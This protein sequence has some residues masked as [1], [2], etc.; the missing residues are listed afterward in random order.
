[1]KP[2][3]T[4]TPM[5]FRLHPLSGALLLY[6]LGCSGVQAVTISNVPLYLGTST[7]PNVLFVLANSQNM[8]ENG[9]P[10]YGMIGAAV[11]GSSPHSKSEIARAAIRSL[12]TTYFGQIN[13]GLMTFGQYTPSKYYM[14]N[15]YYDSRYDP[16]YYNPS[17]VCPS[18]WTA[19]QC[20]ASDYK[21]Y[22]TVNPTDTSNYIY[23]NYASPFYD[24]GPPFSAN[25]CYSSTAK[26]DNTTNVPA[27]SDYY[28]CYST[29]TG[30]S[31]ASPGTSGSGYSGYLGGGGFGP[32]DSDYANNVLDFGARLP[33]VYTSSAWF[34]N[35]SPGGGYLRTP[36][37]ALTSTQQTTINNKLV[38]NMPSQWN[39][40]NPNPTPAWPSTGCNSSTLLSSSIY[41]SGLTAIEG[42]LN[43]AAS[44]F[45]GT[46]STSKGAT[47]GY[48][49]PNSCG[50]NFVVLLTNGLPSVDASGTIEKTGGQ[51]DTC[52]MTSKAITAATNL[53]NNGNGPKLYVVGYALPPFAL[54][55]YN[56]SCGVTGNPL[57]NMAASGGTGT[58][59]TASDPTTLQSSLNTVFTSILQ[60]SGS[61]AAL[62]SNSTSINANSYVYQ[63]SFNTADWSGHLQAI[64]VT[65][66]GAGTPAWDAATRIPTW[67][68]R[69]LL[70]Y[71]GSVGKTFQWNNLTT[72]EQCLLASQASGCTLTSA[73]TTTGQQALNYISGD[74]SQAQSSG[75]ALRN[76]SVLLG[77]IVDSN[78]LYL[79]QDDYGYSILSGT[80]GSSY[81]AYVN[82]KTTPMLYAG[83]NDGMLHAFNSS[84]VEQFA[85]IPSAVYANLPA[86]TQPSY[87]SNHQVYVDGSPGSGD[88]YYA[89]AWHTILIGTLGGGGN[90]IFALD[91]TNPTTM[92]ASN[93]MWEYTGASNMGKTWGQP[94][95]ARFNDGHYYAVVNNGYN[96][97]NGHAVLYLIQVDSPSNVIK[98]DAGSGGSSCTGGDGLSQATL[99]D[100][101]Q[102]GTI[103]AIYAGDL[104]GNIWK[105][106]VSNTMA[107][108]W[109]VAF[110]SGN[111]PLPLFTAKDSIGNLQPIT[112]PLVLG[113][114]PSGT[115]GTAMVFF[116]T[117]QYLGPTDTT[118]TNTQSLYGVL[119]SSTFSSGSFSGG[120]NSMVRSNLQQ[121]SIIFENSV[122]RAVSS[123]S[124]TY[125]TSGTNYG[126]YMD[127]LEPTGTAQIGER[128]ISQPVLRSG[129]IL[130]TTLIPNTGTC[131]YGGTGWAME[132]DAVT[133]GA[134]S[135]T[136][137]DINNDGL[138]D[139]NDNLT[140]S[141]ETTAVAVGMKMTNGFGH[142]PV[143]LT[144]N[145]SL[146]TLTN[147]T[148]GNIQSWNAKSN[149]LSPRASWSQIQ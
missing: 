44:Y 35:G 10:A 120:Q 52:S 122:S 94:W 88:A 41:N 101:D 81:P 70:T 137:L 16:S 85:Y 26:F 139:T 116:G 143:T 83:A 96:S 100:A 74:T 15:S 147:T 55:Y 145:G 110:K 59:F 133:G 113:S 98:I 63:A 130:F 132:L 76:R 54:Q 11:G 39:S 27:G 7:P 36:L 109:A 2:R 105:F 140:L 97:T 108:K 117:G 136:F 146:V 80:E 45:K 19:I 78:P 90:S 149:T 125:P 135:Y 14:Y 111:T 1:M 48:T 28:T 4:D 47:S 31:D 91:V 127:L 102:N 66:S 21:L 30:T 106:D 148:S 92:T 62:T 65:S 107:S 53:Y 123:H 121:Q 33:S 42:T 50:K 20:R 64:P 17:Y 60:S 119:D 6:I 12:E 32:T 131:S 57:D 134:P 56:S 71:N 124:V 114:T 112:A 40:S 8:D 118:N 115:T 129:R 23:Y 141:D 49:L 37:A 72:N 34:Y 46:L 61:S 104:C 144:N 95:V 69:N 3:R 79:S 5:R 75:G 58:S 68:T 22:R 93:V 18:G 82:A 24:N 87:N 99:L 73:Q 67:N 9:D 13:L 86:L 126:W 51:I 84:G 29:K 38:C 89:G 142:T 77:D 128:V 25:F 43:D 103:D 138:Y